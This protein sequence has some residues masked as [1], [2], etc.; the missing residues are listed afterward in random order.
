MVSNLLDRTSLH[1]HRVALAMHLAC[2]LL[3]ESGDDPD[4]RDKVIAIL[5]L[6]SD[7]AHIVS[8]DL[9]TLLAG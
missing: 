8:D 1:V 2:D 7:G 3:I 4:I 9:D 6:A 5:M